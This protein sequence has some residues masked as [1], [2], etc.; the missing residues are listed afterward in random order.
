MKQYNKQHFI[1]ILLTLIVGFSV[2]YHILAQSQ[3]S[4]LQNQNLNYWTR[5]ETEEQ[6]RELA[7]RL[8]VSSNIVFQSKVVCDSSFLSIGHC[9]IVNITQNK[10]T[11]ADAK[12]EFRIQANV[13]DIIV[14][15][16]VGY[17]SLRIEL[18]ET[19]Y[20]YGYV[21]MLKPSAYTLEE[22]TITQFQMN[23]PEIRRSEI[24][25]APLPN[26]GGINIPI[27]ASPI[28]FLYNKYS[29]EAKRLRH[30]NSIIDET[31]EFMLIGEKFNG[32]LVAQITGLKD[33]ELIAFISF[34]DFS[35]YFILNY[36]M[37]TIKRA[38]RQK[39]AEF[40]ER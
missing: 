31:A 26:Q 28:T 30:Y 3:I 18:T 34:C 14:F 36:S 39:Y 37:E 17:E 4:R 40:S 21:A 24:Y 11:V 23:L 29:R 5:N 38:I 7:N 20:N 25:V 35:N 6:K 32:E 16:A 27:S 12:G 33:D 13:G 8:R 1:R 2:H 15:S 10:G 22:I 9:H 19:M